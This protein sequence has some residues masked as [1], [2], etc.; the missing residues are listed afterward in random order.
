M[1]FGD[2]RQEVRECWTMIGQ[3]DQMNSFLETGWRQM[4]R[5]G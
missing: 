5:M 4:D 1:L 3:N 2:R